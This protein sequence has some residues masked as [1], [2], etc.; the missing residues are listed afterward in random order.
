M[1]FYDIA[2][3][4][5]SFNN[6]PAYYVVVAIFTLNYSILF[7]WLYLLEKSLSRRNDKLQKT[8]CQLCRT[9]PKIRNSFECTGIFECPLSAS[10]SEN[11]GDLD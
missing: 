2:T 3:F 6:I 11:N 5:N 10:Q 8:L 4:L 9:Y 1:T 7:V